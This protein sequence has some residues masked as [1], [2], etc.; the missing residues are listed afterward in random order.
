MQEL[1]GR[2]AV[3]TGAAS[4]MGRAFADR[5]A[6]AGMRLVLADIE[7]PALDA[8]VAELTSAGAEAIGVRTDVSSIED[9][10]A[11]RD[12]TLETF[13]QANVICLNAG[14]G[15]GGTME[16]LTP[17]DWQWTLG[18]NLYG[19]VYGLTSFLPH[20][21]SHGDGHVVITASIAGHTSHAGMGP[22]NASK[23]AVATIAETLHHEFEQAESPLG[24]TCLCPGFV[25]TKI[26]ESERNRPETL[27]NPGPAD[28]RT[29]EEEAMRA[30]L[31]EFFANA[32]PASEVADLVHDAVIEKRFWLFTDEQFVDNIAVRHQA[33]QTA[34]NPAPLGSLA[35]RLD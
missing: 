35:D 20:L 27:T 19:V 23:H 17:L 26:I 30:M 34:S 7:E 10:E 14:V 2:T 15:G 18:V 22:Y 33:I 31:H 28:E 24:V 11:L 29:D 12:R 5:F 21:Y 32:K 3:I 16:E 9:N 13:G 8:A 25:S 1:S 6:A 4:G